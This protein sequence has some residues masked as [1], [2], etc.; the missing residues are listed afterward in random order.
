M[1]EVAPSEEPGIRAGPARVD[2]GALPELAR[3]VLAFEKQ[4]WKYLGARETAIREA[5]EMSPVRYSQV[6]NALLDDPA[7]LAHDP[8]TVIRLRE[9]RRRHRTR[10]PDRPATA[11]STN[12]ADDTGPVGP[13][14]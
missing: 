9:H 5:S 3:W 11:G 1:D 4:R 13:G 2:P 8:I 14:S 6:L 7:A 10:N 12:A